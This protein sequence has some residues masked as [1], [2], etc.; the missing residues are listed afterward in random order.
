MFQRKFTAVFLLFF[1]LICASVACAQATFPKVYDSYMELGRGAYSSGDFESARSYF[2]HAR[3]VYPTSEEASY[4]L[5]LI[6]G[7]VSEDPQVEYQDSFEYYPNQQ[8]YPVNRYEA[9]G[10]IVKENTFREQPEVTFVSWEGS[11]TPEIELAQT[12]YSVDF[13]DEEEREIGIPG[14]TGFPLPVGTLTPETPKL[15]EEQEQIPDGENFLYG[16]A[17][18]IPLDETI[19]A[20]QPGTQL[21]IELNQS[22]ILEGRNIRR[23]L[24]LE[25]DVVTVQQ[26]GQDQ[27]MLTALRRG[28]TYVHI[29]DEQRRWTFNVDVILPITK[30]LRPPAEEVMAKYVS[31]LRIAYSIDW[32]S[33]FRGSSWNNLHNDDLNVLQ[34]IGL[35]GETPYGYF[36]GF[37]T[38]NK[39]YESTELVSFGT[40]LSNGRFGDFRDF[41]IR[42]FDTSKELSPLTL[43]GKWYRGFKLD[44]LAFDKQLGY[45]VFYGRDRRTFGIST[46][47]G[48]ELR[49]SYIDGFKATFLPMQED[50]FSFNFAHG[51]GNARSDSLKDRAYSIEGQKRIADVFYRGEVAYDEDVFAYYLTGNYRTDGG[52]LSLKLRD[53]DPEFM[54]VTGQPISSGEVGGLLT[55][56]RNINESFMQGYIDIYRDRSFP[57]EDNPNGVNLD[58][59]TNY[60]LP[61]SSQDRILSGLNYTY[62]PQELSQRNDMRLFSSYARNFSLQNNR[63]VVWNIGGAY[64]RARFPDSPDSEYDRYSIETGVRVPL[65]KSLNYFWNYQ[66]TWVNDFATDEWNFPAVM[67]TGLTMYKQWNEKFG[68]NFS[69][70]YRDEERTGG[71]NSFLAGE[72]SLSGSAGLTY[73]PVRDVEIFFDTRL[74]NIWAESDDREA[75][76]DLD[77]RGGLRSAWDSP[78]VWNPKGVVAGYV[79]KDTNKNRIKDVDEEGIEDVRVQI[80]NDSIRTWGSGRYQKHVRA[81]EVKVT[82]DLDTVPKGFIF[83]TPLSQTVEIIPWKTQSVFFGMSVQTGIYGIVFVDENDNGEYDEGEKLLPKVLIT[84]DGET[85]ATDFEGTY[86]FAELRPGLHTLSIGINSLPPKYLPMVKLKNDLVIEEGSTYVF[87]IP[88][89]ESIPRA[90]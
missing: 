21:K 29:W 82:V 58:L 79:F 19:A 62:T 59:S 72:D 4:Y 38:Y 55:F 9:A 34:W 32:E 44:A 35:S 54:T 7:N 6:D 46:V 15:P 56:N 87:H 78:L 37:M 57:N 75:Y 61:L 30:Y 60:E 27:V 24:V 70:I 1:T 89:R 50:N 42:I 2:N 43:P 86:Q 39:Y 69:L 18:P 12:E 84:V 25:P 41:S 28:G 11:D 17:E 5:A 66:W 8:V 23:I 67:N 47:R 64:Q 80:G 53:I 31:P 20:S 36:D 33:Y 3:L 26:L 14:S 51:Y 63:D 88:V 48:Q 81:K 76:N 40:G 45:S 83:T 85:T 13:A 22:V 16:R 68:G 90:K 10:N 73:T 49:E 71:V 65:A 74:R 77:L 52:G